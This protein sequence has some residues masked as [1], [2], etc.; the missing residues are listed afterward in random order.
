MN[1]NVIPFQRQLVGCK[2]F[3]SKTFHHLLVCNVAF[4]FSLVNCS[5]GDWGDLICRIQDR[6]TCCSNC[7][8]A[9]SFAHVRNLDLWA[10]FLHCR[11]FQGWLTGCTVITFNKSATSSISSEY[12]SN[13]ASLPNVIWPPNQ[14]L[15]SNEASFLLQTQQIQS[16]GGFQLSMTA[17]TR[18]R[19]IFL[20]LLYHKLHSSTVLTFSWRHLLQGIFFHS[21]SVFWCILIAFL[22]SCWLWNDLLAK[23]FKSFDKK[24]WFQRKIVVKMWI[25]L[26]IFP[27]Q[28]SEIV[29][30]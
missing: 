14:I 29:R 10:Y 13:S 20:W 5:S 15:N 24:V 21:A 17:P 11:L 12:S 25:F 8:D 1:W 28:K 6:E 23:A 27:P 26:S 19:P 7:Q 30:K 18:N 2:K 3:A 22:G 16:T 4:L 9:H